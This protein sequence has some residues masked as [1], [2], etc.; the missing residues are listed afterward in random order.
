MI[1]LVIKRCLWVVV[2]ILVI[3][4]VLSGLAD[5]GFKHSRT[6]EYGVWNDIY[7]GRIN[8]DLLVMGSSRAVV[9]VSPLILDSALGLSTY[10]I[11]MAA[12]PF[13]MQYSRLKVYLQHNRKPRYIVEVMD[14]HTLG[15]REDLY[16]YNQFYPYLGD[17]LIREACKG[18]EGEPGYWECRVPFLK[19][20]HNPAFC[21]QGCT[22]Y[23]KSLLNRSETD[24]IKGYQPGDIPWDNTFDAL[25]TQ[26]APHSIVLATDTPSIRAF[27][28]FL[29]F[30]RDNHIGLILLY[31]PEYHDILRYFRN[32]DTI[33]SLYQE[34]ATG[35]RAPFLDYTDDTLGLHRGYYYN[36]QHL[37][38]TGAE[39]FSRQLADTLKYLLR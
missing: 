39:I 8:A 27:N 38:K 10:N 30:C 25:T 32:R 17:P 20:M 16:G 37:N 12:W 2:P 21:F 11:G 14:L 6:W 36:S 28:D 15:D 13:R 35:G 4:S 5:A 26:S 18:Y 23:V 19:Y 3:L 7:D 1:T 31:P 29:G 22:E 9:Q 24:R 34:L 33:M